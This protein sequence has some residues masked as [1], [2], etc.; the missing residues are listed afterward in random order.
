MPIVNQHKTTGLMFEF[1]RDKASLLNNVFIICQ[2]INNY[3]VLI[4]YQF[5]IKLRS[6]ICV[7]ELALKDIAKMAL[8]IKPDLIGINYVFCEQTWCEA[9]KCRT[10]LIRINNKSRHNHKT[11]R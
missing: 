1:L 5:A 4:V 8:L 2:T 3:L 11:I 6:A 10:K 7:C 9:I